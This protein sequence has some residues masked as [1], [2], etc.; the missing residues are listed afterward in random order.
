MKEKTKLYDSEL[1]V[2][3]LLWEGEMS[4]KEI[5]LRLREQAGWSKTTTY[6]VIK[7]CVDKGAVSRTEPGFLCRAE[8]TRSEVQAYETEELLDRMYGGRAD[9]LI[10]ALIGGGRLTADE[11]ASLKKMVEELG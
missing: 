7:K 8:I 2:M 3:E 4:A 1:K 5:A 9:S 6:T 10:A 11:I